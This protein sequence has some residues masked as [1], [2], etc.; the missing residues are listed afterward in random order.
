[1]WSD[2][3]KVVFGARGACYDCES[4]ASEAPK[5]ADHRGEKNRTCFWGTLR[6][7]PM[8]IAFPR[9]SCRGSYQTGR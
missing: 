8:E 6:A 7:N 1:V 4:A 2:E 9:V 5:K 3:F